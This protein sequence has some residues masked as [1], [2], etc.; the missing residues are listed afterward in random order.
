MKHLSIKWAIILLR[1][2]VFLETFLKIEWLERNHL[3]EEEVREEMRVKDEIAESVKA[4]LRLQEPSL[5]Y[6]NGYYGQN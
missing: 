4:I 6:N 3:A 2:I 5:F 1:L